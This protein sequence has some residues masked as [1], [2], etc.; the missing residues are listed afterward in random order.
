MVKKIKGG[1]KKPG[2][3]DAVEPTKS[4]G[5]SKVGDVNQVEGTQAKQETKKSR[6]TTRPITAA[7]RE[8]LLKLINE[9]ADRIF[10]ANGLPESERGTV[11]GA[12]SMAIDATLIEEDE[13]D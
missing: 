7:E 8:H 12:V 1:P 6:K 5:S 4:V 2:G 3:T 11:E 10:G 9:E 13:E